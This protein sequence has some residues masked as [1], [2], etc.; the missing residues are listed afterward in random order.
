MPDECGQNSISYKNPTDEYSHGWHFNH[1]NIKWLCRVS[2]MNKPPDY[3]ANEDSKNGWFCIF[4][5]KWNGKHS[6]YRL[7]LD[8]RKEPAKEN[9]HPGDI[10]WISIKIHNFCWW[11]SSKIIRDKIVDCLK[12]EG[13][14]S[15]W[16]TYNSAVKKWTAANTLGCEYMPEGN[17]MRVLIPV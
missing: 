15:E 17:M 16:Y 13:C 9:P 4:L 2:C 6:R 12:C 11:P 1:S 14:K 8:C 5:Q 10:G 7:F 3:W